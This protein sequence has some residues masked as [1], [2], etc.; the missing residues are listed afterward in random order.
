MAAALGR[1]WGLHTHRR[2]SGQRLNWRMCYMP[3]RADRGQIEPTMQIFRVRTYVRLQTIGCWKTLEPKKLRTCATHH[4][5]WY[6]TLLGCEPL[7]TNMSNRTYVRTY[8]SW[9]SQSDCGAR[10]FRQMNGA[11]TSHWP[12]CGFVA[13]AMLAQGNAARRGHC[14]NVR[15]V[16]LE[17]TVRRL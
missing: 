2:G 6:G 16:S 5:S 10:T 15:V 4:S 17:C 9:A 12:R 8:P 11:G 7:P 14:W 3:R 13:I 1:F